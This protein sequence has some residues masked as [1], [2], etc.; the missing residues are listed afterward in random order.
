MSETEAQDSQHPFV[1]FHVRRREWR[2]ALALIDRGGRH[3]A[4]ARW[5]LDGRLPGDELR[6][7][8]PRVVAGLRLRRRGR[9]PGRQPR[10]V[11]GCRSGAG[12]A[13]P[14]RGSPAGLSR[15]GAGGATRNRLAARLRAVPGSVAR[16]ARPGGWGGP[17]RRRRQVRRPRLLRRRP[18]RRGHRGPGLHPG[19]REGD[20]LAAFLRPT[21]LTRRA[22]SGEAARYG[23][24]L[25]DPAKACP[26]RTRPGR[27]DQ[28]GPPDPDGCLPG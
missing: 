12:R 2:E 3:A 5:W 14:R 8:A 27:P 6:G 11:P 18:G 17:L 21:R 24:G 26:I 10:D 4:I 16:R 9:F 23:K 19:T 15:A 20:R 13:A 28:A 25:P 22:P 7:P 1:N